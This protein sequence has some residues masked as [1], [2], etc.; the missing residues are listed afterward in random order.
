MMNFESR[1]E[2]MDEE[3][4]GLLLEPETAS[5]E[6]RKHVAECEGCRRELDELKATMGLM[7][8]WQAPEPSPFFF[9]RMNARMREERQAVPRGWLARFK[10]SF[11]YGPRTHMKPLAA[12]VL[13]VAMLVGG[14]AYLGLS[15]WMQPPHSDDAAVVN[16]LQVMENNAQVLDTL[17][18]LSNAQ[19]D[20]N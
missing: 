2:K 9:T 8:A 13:T 6:V 12:M 5:A 18:A 20:G 14:G 11:V 17:E 7:D 16:D 4:A 15:N 1:C 19:D 3:L 10:A